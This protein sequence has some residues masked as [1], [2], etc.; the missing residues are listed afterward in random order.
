MG[1][2]GRRE[3]GGGR[4]EGRGVGW[5]RHWLEVMLQHHGLESG[6]HLEEQ[7]RTGRNRSLHGRPRAGA[8]LTEER[9]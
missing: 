6:C 1:E 7:M 8:R 4:K 2:E 9:C 5:A 3:K